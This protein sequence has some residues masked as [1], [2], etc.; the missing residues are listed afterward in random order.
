MK[1]NKIFIRKAYTLAEFFT[2]LV[3]LACVVVFSVVTVVRD[4]KKIETSAELKKVYFDISK[5]INQS[6]R[7]SGAPLS[8]DSLR[9]VDPDV[10]FEIYW[11]SY[12]ENAVLC[13]T[14][15]DCGYKSKVGVHPWKTLNGQEFIYN[16]SFGNISDIKSESP[17]GILFSYGK[18]T[19]IAF[20]GSPLGDPKAED[21]PFWNSAEYIAL[22]KEILGTVSGKELK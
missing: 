19:V 15:S 6:A 11:E 20:L 13:A 21:R 7:H 10:I 2:S 3:I 9:D 22:M 17:F 14:P 12:L 5:A 18:G 4:Y 1:N 8:F 16:T